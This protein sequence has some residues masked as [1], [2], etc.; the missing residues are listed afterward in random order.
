MDLSSPD[1]WWIIWAIVVVVAGVGEMLTPGAFFLLPFAL[2]ALAAMIA[3]LFD[4]PV[5]LGWLLFVS[6]SAP[7]FAAFI[8]LRR[9]LDESQTDVGVGVKR[10]LDKEAVVTHRIGPEPG[11]AGEIRVERELWRATGPKGEV[12]EEGTV[13]RIVGVE[14]TRALVERAEAPAAEAHGR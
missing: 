10:L 13:V 7:S 9:R 11:A 3:S 12:L 6:V 1:T 8:P 2:G 5:W 4:A 14:G